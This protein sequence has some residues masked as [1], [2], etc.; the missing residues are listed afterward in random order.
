MGDLV[1][2]KMMAKETKAL[3]DYLDSR[4]LTN[5]EIK[6]ICRDIIEFKNFEAATWYIENLK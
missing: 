3:K 6:L 2:K 1:N 4:K 5:R